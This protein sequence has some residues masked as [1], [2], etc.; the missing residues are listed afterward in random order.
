MEVHEVVMLVSILGVAMTFIFLLWRS[1]GSPEDV[2]TAFKDIETAIAVAQEMVFAAEQLWETG[3]L[4]KNERFDYV[5][6]K[7]EMIFPD[8]DIDTLEPL[9]EAAVKYAKIIAPKAEA[10]IFGLTS[11]DYEP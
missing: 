9:I 5:L 10:T 1:R 8:L 4:P 2:L 6:E 7:M 11:P 3:E